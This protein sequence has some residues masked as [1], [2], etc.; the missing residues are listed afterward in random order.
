MILTGAQVYCRRSKPSIGKRKLEICAFN[1]Y[2]SPVISEHHQFN[3]TLESFH[4]EVYPDDV[5]N[6]KLFIA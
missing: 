2:A 5:Q 4:A 1:K 6:T 3:E